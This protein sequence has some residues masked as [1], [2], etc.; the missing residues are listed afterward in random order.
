[1]KDYNETLQYLFNLQRLGINLNLARISRVLHLLDNPHNSL[2]AVHIAGTNGKGSVAAIMDS[3]LRVSG[4]KTGL[5]T[6]PHL[7]D[8]RERIRI[9]G[10]MISEEM[11][12][13]ITER[14]REIV[15]AGLAPALLNEELTFFE[16]ITVMA[17][18]YLAEEGVDIAIVETGMGGRLDATNVLSTPLISV[19][20]DIDYDHTDFLG[21]TM[22]EIARE[23]GGI[24]KEK[25]VVVTT[26]QHPEVISEIESICKER[27]AGLI[28]LGRDFYI[29][30]I[31]SDDK[32]NIFNLKSN[33]NLLC[34][35]RIPL[36][37]VHQIINAGVAVEVCLRLRGLGFDIT[38]E[39]IKEGLDKVEW[40]GRMEI[41]SESPYILLDGAHNR[42][43]TKAL[44]KT[45][46]Y[47]RYKR[48]FI[49]IGILKD[50]D[51]AGMIETLVPI[52]DHV[53][54][55]RPDVPRGADPKILKDMA[56]IFSKET[57][58]I[59]DIPSALQK[60]REK[61]DKDDMILI[62]GSLF[63]VAEARRELVDST[64]GL[65]P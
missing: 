9:N 41:I 62:T 2:M 20:T 33:N 47:F 42:A 50:K 18:I 61:I 44:V 30:I 19:I 64:Q 21:N 6:S 32:G 55:V 49:V 23:K 16:F 3:I 10:N 65:M 48:L 8:L 17:F 15:G 24:I 13:K 51:I 4:Y 27:N 25:G 5:Y 11:T 28:I 26:L 14:I 1:M 45:L 57:V 37:G 59:E 54:L 7:Y 34:D 29:D 56:S 53:T 22:R 43:G 60:V 36:I 58:I 35:L 46:P 39:G 12:V 38:D 31:R 40:K 52:A 63:T